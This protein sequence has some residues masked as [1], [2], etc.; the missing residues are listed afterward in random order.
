MEGKDVKSLTQLGVTIYA[1][2]TFRSPWL[3]GRE[4]RK[5]ES[6]KNIILESLY[7]AIN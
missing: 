7:V 3:T 5:R 4:A 1:S 2:F 6:R